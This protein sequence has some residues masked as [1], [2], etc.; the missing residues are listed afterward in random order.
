MDMFATSSTEEKNYYDLLEVSASASPQE[1][2]MAYIRA[3]TAYRKDSV[4]LYSLISEEETEDMLRKIEEAFQTLS[5]SERR[6]EYDR[7]H[8][9][10]SAENVEGPGVKTP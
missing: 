6:R 8:G 2:R 3:K 1:I 5:N 7:K 4:A 9:V 10:L